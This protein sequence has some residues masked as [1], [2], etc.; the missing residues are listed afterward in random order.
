MQQVCLFMHDPREVHLPLIKRILK[1]VKRTAHLGLQLHAGSSSELVAYSDVDWAGC[2]DTRKST[3]GFCIFLGT[4]LVSWSSK[5]HH[6]VSRSS[7]EGEY[8]AVAN[9]VAESVWLHQ[10]LPELNQPASK[11][12][13]V[14]CVNISAT[15]LST[16]HVQH[17]Q[18]KHV[19]IDLHFA[20]HRVAFGEARILHVPSSSQFADIFTKGLPT[21]VFQDLRTSLNI[22][23]SPVST[24]GVLRV[25]FVYN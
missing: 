11:A 5:Q 9:S 3:S 16:N 12:T 22:V 21:T 14:Y 7:A 6:T 20:S 24:V 15:Y 4:N 1:Y 10:L 13:V 8:R 2:P 18:T 19:E 23:P 25:V 17:Q